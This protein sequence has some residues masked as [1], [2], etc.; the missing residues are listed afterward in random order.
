MSLLN[1]R[2]LFAPRPGRAMLRR[3]GKASLRLPA[4]PVSPVLLAAYRLTRCPL[5]G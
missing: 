5:S 1:A 4:P 3:D 2:G